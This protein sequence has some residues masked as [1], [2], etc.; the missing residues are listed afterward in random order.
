MDNSWNYLS[1]TCSDFCDRVLY[2]GFIMAHKIKTE[3][4]SRVSGYYRPIAQW[5]KG[6]QSE[7]KDREYCS[8][9][10]E[11]PQIKLNDMVWSL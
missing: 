6:K 7:F 5:N 9:P 3:V 1:Y 11:N 2:G 4:Y 10:K 8:I